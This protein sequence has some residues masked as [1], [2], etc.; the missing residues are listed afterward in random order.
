M[1]LTLAAA[2]SPFEVEGVTKR[3]HLNGPEA[4][5]TAIRALLQQ[6]LMSL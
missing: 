2:F 5:F 4:E 3:A 1:Y 6:Q